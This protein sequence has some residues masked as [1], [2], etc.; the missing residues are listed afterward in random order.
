MLL[1]ALLTVAPLAAR[2]QVPRGDGFQA[3]T[4]TTGD[5]ALPSVASLPGGGFVVVWNSLDQD[6][7][8]YGIF[9]RRYD[10]GGEALDGEDIR[11]N[12]S[13]TGSQA[14]PAVAATSTAMVVAWHSTVHDGSGHGVFARR[15]DGDGAPVGPEFRVNTFTARDQ[16]DAAVAVSARG[17]VIA[18]TSFEQDGSGQGVFAQRHDAGGGLQGPE[19]RVHAHT[20][21]AQADPAVASDAAGNFV[22]AWRSAGQDGDAGGIYARRFDA[23]GVPQG[24]EFRLNAYTTGDQAHPA[25]AADGTGGFVAVWA[26]SGQDGA[27]EGVYGRRYAADGSPRGDEFQVHVHTA[28]FQGLPAVAADAS[29]FVVAWASEVPDDGLSAIV[30]R[31]FDGSGAAEG[32][33]FRVNTFTPGFQLFPSVA[34]ADRGD[35]VIAWMSEEEDGNLWGVFGRRFAPDLIFRDGFE[36]GDLSSW[37]GAQT[38]GS[39]LTV[40]SDAAMAGTTQGLRAVVDDTG[41]L[42]VQD[43]SPR[44]EPR[45]RMRLRF[46]TNGFDP[47]EAEGHFRVRLFVAFEDAP[48]RRL[49]TLVLKRQDGAYA[50]MARARLDDGTTA[51]T[52]F[53]AV[54]DG[55]HVVEMDWTRASGPAVRDGRLDLWIDGTAAATLTG[56]DNDVGAVD[57]VRL[58]ALSVK[59]GATGTL[60]W[61]EFESRRQEPIGP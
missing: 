57:F 41:G 15:Y 38:G 18:W 9:G 52:A 39:D 60:Y 58:G 51:D 12:T 1:A 59:G 4:Y 32:G 47:G 17:F 35:F 53:V 2:A 28:G 26:S 25:L 27:G 48:T 37:S 44:D 33:E 31:R 49:L 40:A 30:A 8:A 5:Q 10:A 43:D 46:D 29:G 14:S 23:Q 19:F 54:G 55:P 21:G 36:T 20:T 6:G 42:Y 7:S 24:E 56:L 22:I 45:Y 34:S 11:V 50:L 13:T 16:N 3:N 61:D